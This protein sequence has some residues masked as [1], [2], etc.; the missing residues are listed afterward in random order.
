MRQHDK[1]KDC[2]KSVLE[3]ECV[4]DFEIVKFWSKFM[5]NNN[6]RASKR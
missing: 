5:V 4:S 6:K 3:C 1:C 2:G